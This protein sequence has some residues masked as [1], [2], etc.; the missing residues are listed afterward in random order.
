MHFSVIAQQDTPLPEAHRW[1][2]VTCG[3]KP[4]VT[5]E[6]DAA[7]MVR[8]A[9]G[10]QEFLA[11]L[12][13]VDPSVAADFDLSS[14]M[15]AFGRG[16]PDPKAEGDKP[17]RLSNFRA[18]TAEVLAK[19][20]LADVYAIDFPISEQAGKQ[21]ANQPVLGFDGCGFVT[22]GNSTALVLVTVKGSDDANRPPAIAQEL[23]KE[24]TKA[25][26]EPDKLCRTLTAL[27]LRV[28]SA[29]VKASI[30]KMLE[31][32]GKAVLPKI[33][34]APVLVRGKISAH[35]DDLGSVMN[36]VANFSPATTYG[37]VLGVGIT[38]GDFGHSVMLKA[39]AD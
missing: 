29:A 26:K 14:I 37:L 36:A 22:I 11:Q 3:C 5:L 7:A 2:A 32:L 23:I 10:E 24:C 21:N 15:K 4:D 27:L 35:L 18:E 30:I 28:K 8:A 33:V 19:A 16:L 25:P 17:R 13:Q 20:A 31:L 39:R 9:Y 12:G 1:A 6:E 34:V 38:L